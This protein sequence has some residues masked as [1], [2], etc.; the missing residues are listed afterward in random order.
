MCSDELPGGP[1]SHM[2]P[3]CSRRAE[4]D[5]SVP[6]PEIILPIRAV[7]QLL[8]VTK[9]L[10]Q[11]VQKLE[12][13]TDSLAWSGEESL[14][15][16][17]EQRL[18]FEKLLTDLSAIFVNIPASE[19]DAQIQGVLQ[20]VGEILGIDRTAFMQYSKD[21]GQIQVTHWWAAEGVEAL[22]RLITDGNLLMTEHI[23]WC[24]EKTMLGE[25]VVF[26]SRDELPEE[27]AKDK[28][29]FE[30]IGVESG[31]I[32]PYFVE[33]A[34]LFTM[35]FGTVRSRRS[36]PEE[37]IQRLKLLG[38][39]VSNALLRKQADLKLQAV[40]KE[41]LR[42]E[43]L[44][45]ELSAT[46]VKTPASE[47]DERVEGV[48][49]CIGE[50]LGV[51]RTD[52]VQLNSG[53]GQLEI[54]HSWT[55]KGIEPYSRIVTDVH[56]PW[57][58]EQIRS[59]EN[60]ILFSSPDDLPREALQDKESLK[61]MGIKSGMIIP[62]AVE[63]S[64]LGAIAFG[65]HRDYRDS[66]P[67]AY[68]QRLRILGEVIFNAILRKQA[69]LE[70]RKAFSE[71]Q[72]L[73]DRLE[74]ENIC[75]REEIKTIEKHPEIIGESDGIKEVLRKIEQVADTDSTVLI[76]GETGVG[77]EL[78][79]RAIHNMS[80]RKNRPMVTVNCAALPPTLVEAELFGRE[81][82][83]YTGAMSK[84]VGRFE[85]ADGSTIFL[86]EIGELPMEVQVKLLRVLEQGQFERLGSSK[87]ISVDVRVIAATNRDL[88]KALRDGKF[89]EDLYYRLNVFPIQV[90]PLR[91][92]SEDILP[93]TWAFIKEFGDTM[94]KR[95]K[96]ISRNSLDA[97]R[98]YHWPG[99]VR[100][101]RNVIER[102]MIT[103][104]GRTLSVELPV[105]F[106]GGIPS[107]LT[108]E[109]SERRHILNVLENTGWRIR[110][111]NGAAEILGLKPTTLYS[112]MKKLGI[113]RPDKSSYILTSR[114]NI[115]R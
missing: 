61:K 84:Q 96:A 88:V 39:I 48:L 13:K 14:R 110:G 1:F 12:E 44:L 55:A 95:V 49:Q 9:E 94:G 58:S 18:R 53:S 10:E 97:M 99:N 43:K 30:R 76:L 69:D 68:I 87:T 46:F 5:R 72:D 20:R 91:E 41:R 57:F 37:L 35:T 115:D 59:G 74:R 31:V 64:F 71:I 77:K 34:F 93:L 29:T 19:V 32:I 80:S 113:H 8:N 25:I 108:L 106:S 27:A 103:S 92:R 7:P 38:E 89:R 45:A 75:L 65:T 3:P 73:K 79:A 107:D 15:T 66:W 114:L 33:G 102:A 105:T 51:D 16:K 83:A 28:R 82:G 98:R 54:T 42:F 6:G 21:L 24:S 67:E 17:L 112:K 40:H 70:L 36:W 90:P 52:F 4:K 62:Y 81:K 47:V 63:G 2:T 85:I 11:K 56:Y 23:P 22:S 60:Y 104:K 101:L 100:E 111:R 78:V 26:S 86:D 109:E 50:M